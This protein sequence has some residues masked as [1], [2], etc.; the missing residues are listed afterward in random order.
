MSLTVHAFITHSTDQK[1]ADNLD[2]I[3]IIN[4]IIFR[5]LRYQVYQPGSS[6]MIKMQ[7][8]DAIFS[9]C[10]LFSL[11]GCD[12]GLQVSTDLCFLLF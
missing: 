9:L 11:I 2:V 8:P 5:K 3:I 7:T 4:I 12:F 6:F 10:M 1:G